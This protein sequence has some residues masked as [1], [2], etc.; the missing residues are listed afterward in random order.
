MR[1]NELQINQE[2][3]IKEILV[4]D[5]NLNLRLQELGLYKKSK[6]KILFYSPLKQTLLIKIFNSAFALKL[7]IA[8]KILVEKV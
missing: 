5:K 7:N 1:L 8:S 3:I 6:I 2:A 4:E